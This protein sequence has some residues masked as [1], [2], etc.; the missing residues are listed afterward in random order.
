MFAHDILT[1]LI[2]ATLLAL[3]PFPVYTVMTSSSPNLAT[4]NI[5][6]QNGSAEAAADLYGL[7]IRVGAYLQV[8]GMLLSCIGYQKR[9]R[10][11][12]KLLS[13][14]VC[15]AILAS[16]TAFVCRREISP[17]E[18]W[19]VL[20]LVNAYGTPRSAAIKHW[21]TKDGGGVAFGF[22]LV[23]LVWQSVS[24]M[25]FFATLFHQLPILGTNN[26]V[27]LFTAVD[28][29]GW[30][31]I[32]MLV[33][34]SLC[35]L[36]L[37]VEIVSYLLL[38]RTAFCSWTGTK[39]IRE[40]QDNESVDETSGVHEQ[41]WTWGGFMRSIARLSKHMEEN[42]VFKLKIL[43]STVPLCHHWPLLAAAPRRRFYPPS[44]L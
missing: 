4:P 31:R 34:S 14:A 23:S 24:F 19:L 16:W 15:V 25:W 10:T 21:N 9:S 33:Y 43:L 35:C 12:I 37:P 41:F 44:R 20:S 22:A 29:S 27:W 38:I 18:A 7:G 3:I 13:S 32:L 36:Y 42:I 40:R 11:G 28:I 39:T 1:A 17:C 26:R 8:F 6:R 30:F 5:R 2:V